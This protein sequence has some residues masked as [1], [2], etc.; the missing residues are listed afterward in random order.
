MSICFLVSESRLCLCSGRLCCQA[1]S[2]LST[3]RRTDNFRWRCTVL[4]FHLL[5]TLPDRLTHWVVVRAA[6]RRSTIN[7]SPN[8]EDH[9]RGGIRGATERE[10][11][12]TRER[13]RLQARFARSFRARPPTPSGSLVSLPQ[14]DHLPRTKRL[15]RILLKVIHR[16]F[17]TVFTPNLTVAIEKC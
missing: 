16:V 14:S 12:K 8:W 4:A 3:K 13:A 6:R 5:T 1:V 11:A 2:C 7:L 15:L 10:I 17:G 9:L